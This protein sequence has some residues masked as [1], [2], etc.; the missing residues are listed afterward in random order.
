MRRACQGII[1]VVA[2]E[3]ENPSGR[4]ARG[5]PR[6]FDRQEA[7]ETA[8]ALFQA[9]G[10]EGTSIADLTD[11]IGVTATSLY[12]AFQSKEALFEEAVALYQQRDGAFAAEALERPGSVQAAIRTLLTQAAQHYAASDR[13]GGCFISLGLLSCGPDHHA[14]AR[15]MTARRIAARE[16][17]KARLDRGKSQGELPETSDTEA[18]AAFYAATLQGLSVQARDGASE[19]DLQAIVDL[20]LLPLCT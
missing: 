12:G 19:Q 6:Q 1:A 11:A 4:R 3:I 18:L 13:P 17:I 16:A 8:L 15:R 20:A 9:R 14:I 2:M 7:L 10:Y 5:R